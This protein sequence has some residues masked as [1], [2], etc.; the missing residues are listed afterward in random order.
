MSER[1][2]ASTTRRTAFAPCTC[3]AVRGSP[4]RAAQRPLPSMMM[5]ACIV[6]SLAA[7]GFDDGFDVR[8]I[9]VERLAAGGRQA[10][11]RSRSP[12]FEALAAADV[13]GV[14]ELARMRAQV[15]V[16]HVEQ[17]LQIIESERLVHGEGAHDSEPHSSVYEPVDLGVLGIEGKHRSRAVLLRLARPAVWCR[18][19]ALACAGSSVHVVS[20]RSESRR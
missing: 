16:R 9:A 5:A 19:L 17:R 13:A 4:R 7:H 10:V 18:I 15:S 8:E 11:L 14:L 2:A 3:P 12:S 1:A 20:T 6:G